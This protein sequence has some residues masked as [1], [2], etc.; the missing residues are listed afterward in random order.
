ML[1]ASFPGDHTTYVAPTLVELDQI[2]FQLALDVRASGIPLEC[3]VVISNGALPYS[4]SVHN[5]LGNSGKIVT[6]GMSYYDFD[7][8][9]AR[10]EV[11]QDLSADVRGKH[12][13][14]LDE[15]VDRGGTMPVARDRVLEAGAASIHT[16]ALIFKRRSVF[17]PDFVGHEVE[18]EWVVFPHDVRPA[19]E[20]L[21]AR[22]LAAGVPFD[23]VRARLHYLFAPSPH[24]AEQVDHYCALLAPHELAGAVRR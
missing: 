5:H 23:E 13:F 7:Q 12:V 15:V 14:L 3:T 6:I 9:R 18:D 24:L 21:G 10:A 20:K 19:I 8:V 16:G 11:V 17:R 1:R 2:G 4:L 22:W